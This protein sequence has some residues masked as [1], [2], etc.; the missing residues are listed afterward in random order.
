MGRQTQSYRGHQLVLHG[1]DLKGIHSQ[2]SYMPEDNIGV[3]VFV[4]GDH[5]LTYNPITYNIYEH[6]LGLSI[7]PW[8]ER[9]LKNRDANKKEGKEGREKD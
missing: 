9:G 5:S 2:I 4:I 7:T 3:I 8:S 1:G 6:L